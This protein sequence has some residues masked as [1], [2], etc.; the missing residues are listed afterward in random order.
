MKKIG[1]LTFHSV[2]NYGGMLQAYAL[3]K[4][5]N[6]NGFDTYTI[7]Y[8]SPDVTNEYKL[9]YTDIKRLGIKKC[10][11]G[12]IRKILNLRTNYKR[13]KEFK[14]FK[15]TYIKMT[16]RL[17]NKKDIIDELNQ[18][19]YDY[20]ITGSDQV[21]NKQLTGTSEEIYLLDMK[22]KESVKKVS[23]A[24]SIGN[25]KISEEELKKI[26]T[27]LNDYTYISVRE[28]TLNE[29]LKEISN[30]KISTVLDPTLLL[31]DKEWKEIMCKD[32]VEEKYICVYMLQRNDR[33]IEVVN[34]I[35]K[36]LNLKVIHFDDK[37]IYQNELTNYYEAGPDK[38]ISIIN[39]AEFVI[40][41][42]FHGMVFSILLEKQFVAI[43]HTTRSS[44]QYNLLQSL[45]LSDRMIGNEKKDYQRYINEK[46]DYKEVKNKL[47]EL[48][49]G[50]IEFLRK[51]EC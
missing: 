25:D 51:L 18:G 10:T 5:L 20:I 48:K 19:K 22:L 13:K 29:K 32:R 28:N 37:K 33:I 34:N 14:K 26:D 40:T 43:P 12:N 15:N 1:I 11:K 36:F 24:A 31:S 38:F 17:K 8:D 35:S 9:I 21:W 50:T 4:Y 6:K 30:K 7:D 42:S 45:K 23:Y 2:L 46:I 16:E 27:I 47:E 41:N 49:E 39:N 44:R 3:N